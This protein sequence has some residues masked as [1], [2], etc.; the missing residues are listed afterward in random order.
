PP[1]GAARRHVTLGVGTALPRHAGP[2]GRAEG[3]PEDR[4]NLPRRR[5]GGPAS[6]PCLR[7]AAT[8]PTTRR[9]SILALHGSLPR[10]RPGFSSRP[11]AATTE[12]WPALP[13]SLLPRRRRGLR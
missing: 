12:A 3:P 8:A 6:T 7:N 11:H 13:R 5:P 10:R 2:P 1:A 4:R 9:R